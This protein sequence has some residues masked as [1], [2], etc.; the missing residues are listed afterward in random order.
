LH[1][2]CPDKDSN[3]IPRDTIPEFSLRD[4]RKT[5]NNLSQHRWYSTEIQTENL[6]N[7]SLDRCRN[8]VPL[9][10]VLSHATVSLRLVLQ[11]IAALPTTSYMYIQ[12]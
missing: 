6:R 5:T 3:R 8:T 9:S 4:V 2:W 11:K 1:R 7:K 10:D 12:H